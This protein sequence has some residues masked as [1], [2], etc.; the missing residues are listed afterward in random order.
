[1]SEITH[2]Q[3]AVDNAALPPSTSRFQLTRNQSQRLVL[4]V[5]YTILIIGALTMLLPF[6]WMVSTAFKPERGIFVMPPQWIPNP[7]TIENFE[8]VW[9]NTNLPRAFLNSFFVAF[10][11]T[12]GEVLTSTMAGFAFARLKFRG[13]NILFGILLSTLMIPGVV[14]LIPAF[15]LF[16]TL[17]WVGTF[18]P[19]IIPILFGTPFAVFLS[20]QFFM[21]LPK[22]LED[23]AKV[24]GCNVFQIYWN[25]FLPLATPILAT[26]FVLGFIARWNDYLGP[27]IYLSGS[28]PD[29]YTIPLE[30]ASL[31]SQYEQNWTLLMA[32]A[33]LALAPIV[34]LFF[35]F[36]RYFIE[37]IALTGIKG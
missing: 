19:L 27:L 10:V 16:R 34:V 30:L 20:R 8:R 14:T 7:F 33:T 18:N 31:Q 12:L 1:M 37:S 29:N 36:Q 32:G 17:G 2:T 25:I 21:T 35:A 24:D 6:F 22:E 4:L 9:N 11:T 23:A 26:L 5:S 28:S 3:S 15:I 13:Q